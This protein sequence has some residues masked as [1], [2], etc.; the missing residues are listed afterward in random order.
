M[1]LERAV[2][3]K[4]NSKRNPEQEHAAREWIEAVTGEKF[5]TDAYDESLHDGILLCKLMNK[6][7]PGSV[8]K[9]HTTGNVMKLRENAGF[10]QQAA[11]AYGIGENDVFQAVDLF[12]KKNISQVTMCVFALSRLAQKHNFAGPKLN[13]QT[14]LPVYD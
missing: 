14:K 3:E 1:A 10:F 9:I 13:Y 2:Q 5:P 11:L 8:P 6:I 12:D 7:K 4:I